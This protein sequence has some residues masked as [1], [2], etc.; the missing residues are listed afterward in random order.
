MPHHRRQEHRRAVLPRDADRGVVTLRLLLRLG[1]LG[2]NALGKV[3]PLAQLRE[4]R[5]D[6]RILALDDLVQLGRQRANLRAGLQQR[7]RRPQPLPQ[8]LEPLPQHVRKPLAE[9][10]E[11]ARDLVGLVIP[12]GAVDRQQLAERFLRKIEA[13]Q[14]EA[15]GRGHVADRRFHGVGL[16]AAA[17]ENPLD[18]PQVLAVAG[19][20]EIAVLVGAEPIDVEDLGRIGH[21]AAHVQPV[22]EV[23]AHVVAAER[24]HRHRIVPHL[25]D[26]ADLR[27]GALRGHRRPDEHA[28]LP[29]ER[30][31]HQRRQMRAAAAEE[32]RRDRHAVVVLGAERMRRALRQRR[33]EAGVR[34]ARRR[35]GCPFSSF[36]PGFHGRP[37]QS[38]PSLGGSP[39]PPS[40]HTPPSLVN[41][42]FV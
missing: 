16:A 26:L 10:V 6:V 2:Q 7:N 33:G 31:V 23:V 22:L 13:G 11:E 25:A 12:I 19:P 37:C 14:V 24:Q 39:S 41:T 15:F 18:H 30:L 9:R 5:E 3:Q 21:A 35:I 1:A 8:L 36:M 34:D 40:H 4:H 32:D 20:E 17:V 28:V 38:Q 27:G 29:V 42:T